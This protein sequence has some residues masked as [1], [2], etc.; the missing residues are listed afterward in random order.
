MRYEQRTDTDGRVL[1]Q[2]VAVPLEDLVEPSRLPEWTRSSAAVV[3]PRETA[4]AQGLVRTDAAN[5]TDDGTFDTSDTDAAG[6][7]ADDPFADDAQPTAFAD[8][9]NADP[10][11]VNA[12]DDQPDDLAA[13]A[14]GQKIP[15]DKLWGIMGRVLRRAAPIPSLE[16][17]GH[18]IPI[19]GG[20]TNDD[21]MNDFGNS[22]APGSTE[23]PTGDEQ[24][25]DFGEPS[26]EVDGADD[27]DPF[28]SSPAQPGSPPDENEDMES[29]P[30]EPAEEDPFGG[31]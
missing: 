13:S 2:Q 10:F 17:L 8:A 21:T 11:A 16:G 24:P 9:P 31:F 3:A 6:P 29:A 25:F 23:M 1:R 22:A 20:P 4:A 26:S 15:P 7:M 5:T 12:A 14:D 19:P 28:G 27:S 18:S 30:S